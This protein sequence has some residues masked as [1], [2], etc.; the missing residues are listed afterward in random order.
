MSGAVSAEVS[1]SIIMATQLF[2][3]ISSVSDH[4]WLAIS[5]VYGEIDE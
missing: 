2:R 4:Y 1:L 3:D 5:H